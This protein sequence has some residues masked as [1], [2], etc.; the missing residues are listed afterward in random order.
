[1]T[2]RRMLGLLFCAALAGSLGSCGLSE[3]NPHEPQSKD[4]P[5]GENLDAEAI[6]DALSKLDCNKSVYGLDKNADLKRLQHVPLQGAAI[7]LP[8]SVDDKTTKP[9]KFVGDLAKLSGA[10]QAAD[11]L[12]AGPC[13]E[14][15]EPL[16]GVWVLDAKGS[17]FQAH[18]PSDGCSE[19]LGDWKEQNLPQETL[20]DFQ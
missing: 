3:D 16:L 14:M 13:L 9:R 4:T 18:I 1:M 15:A 10:L 8:E 5:L 2:A 17:L 19:H 12:P 20:A 11:P 6:D 7:C